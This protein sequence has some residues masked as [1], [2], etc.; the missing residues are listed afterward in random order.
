MGNQAIA[1]VPLC[2]LELERRP[3]RRPAAV[4]PGSGSRVLVNRFIETVHEIRRWSSVHGLQVPR[5]ESPR[6]GSW[7]RW[8][9]L[10]IALTAL[11]KAAALAEIDTSSHFQGHER[12]VWKRFIQ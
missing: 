10:L 9:G 3:P 1:A 7:G 5:G 11:A 6:A 8:N 2:G 4:A 12:L